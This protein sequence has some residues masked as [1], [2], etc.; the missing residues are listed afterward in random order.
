MPS[1]GATITMPFSASFNTA[2]AGT[3]ETVEKQTFQWMEDA[4][5][6]V[7]ADMSLSAFKNAFVLS[8][9]EAG[10]PS[11]ALVVSVT[12]SSANIAAFK[13]ALTSA[14]ADA[15]GAG[16]VSIRHWLEGD[17]NE[18]IQDF[19]ASNG[20]PGALEAS[21]VVFGLTKFDVPLEDADAD[22]SLGAAAMWTSIVN[23]TD[24]LRRL[25]ALQLN[26]TKF[27]DV[28]SSELPVA[29]GDTVLFRFVIT[30]SYT[31]SDAPVDL[32][33]SDPVDGK[34]EDA[35]APAAPT[36]TLGYNATRTVDLR[37]TL[38]APAA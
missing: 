27:P 32:V 29:D 11:A 14:L 31:I 36:F 28:F 18:S 6:N 5:L 23:G 38:K 17:A 1:V 25:I 22:I 2:G 21:A 12:D 34:H 4:S 26:S 10:D 35:L 30:Q 16:G 24:D 9:E 13:A 37:V 3:L 19:I 7:A 33:T 15:S 20:V 8:Q